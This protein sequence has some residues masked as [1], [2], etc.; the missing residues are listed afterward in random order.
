MATNNLRL[1]NGRYVYDTTARNIDVKKAIE[2]RPSFSPL[3]VYEGE[4]LQEKKNM[5][6]FYVLFLT[7]AVFVTAYALV[8]YLRLQS[9]IAN[10]VENIAIYEQRLN[11]LTLANDDEYSKMINAIDYDEIKRIAIEELGMVYASEDQIVTYTR[12]NSDYVRQL[13]DISK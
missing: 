5:S 2:E 12:E 13:S 6:F 10:S 11:N 1:S 3:K 8:S 7:V 4:N 9:E